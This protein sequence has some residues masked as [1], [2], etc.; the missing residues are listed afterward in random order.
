MCEHT[1]VVIKLHVSFWV[2]R[3]GLDGI[4]SSY[5]HDI[6]RAMLLHIRWSLL[7]LLL[8]HGLHVFL[9]GNLVDVDILLVRN[10]LVL[11]RCDLLATV[12]LTLTNLLRCH[13]GGLLL[14]LEVLDW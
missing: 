2:S 12:V 11:S 10:G 9:L 5:L 4:L 14:C 8:S 3:T 7:V 1:H 6:L 13:V